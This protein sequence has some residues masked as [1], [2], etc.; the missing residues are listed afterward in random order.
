VAL[1]EAG[2]LCG[3]GAVALGAVTAALPGRMRAGLLLQAAG[4]AAA[5]AAALAVLCGAG[6]IG[7]AFT[8]TPEPRVGVD[9]LSAFFLVLLAVTAIPA[10]LAARDRLSGDRS[11]RAVAA[12]TGAFLLA[13]GGVL[14][15]RDVVTLLAAWELMSLAPAAA[16]LAARR[17]EPVRR[18][19]Y[20]YLA[21]THLGGTGV[22]VALLTLAHHGAVGDPAALAA[23]GA[24]VQ[25][26]VAVTA[27]VGFGTKAGLVPLHTWLPR[28]H[29]VAP[30]HLSALM[31][32]VMVKVA[33]YGLIRVTLEWLGATPRW[34][35]LAL[36]ASG[37]VSALGGALWALTRRD[38]KRLLAYS[39][40]ENVGIVALALGAAVLLA[41]AGRPG[42]AALAFAAALLH[43]AN[44]AIFKVLLFLAAGAIERAAG[45]L[46]LDRLGGLLR[47]M[48][49]TGGA[50]LVGAVAIAGL[51]PLN[52]FASEW[53]ALQ[54][55]AHLALSAGPATGVPGAVALAGLAAAAALAL[56]AFVVAAG[57]VLLGAPRR[58]ACAQAA[59]P[60]RA[61]RGALCALAALCVALGLVP[62]LLLPTL[63][64]L[65][66][67]SAAGAALPDAGA[68][69]ALPGTG[70]L[71]TV[72][73]AV[74][75]VGLAALL[76]RVRRGGRPAAAPAP[77]WACGQ[78]AVPALGWTAAGFTKPLRLGLERVLR[79]RREIEVVR[80]GGLVRRVRYAGEI[81]S[82]VDTV[83]Y[84]P[85]IRVALRA[86]TVARRLQSGSVRTYAV[87][88]LALVVGLLALVR[89]GALR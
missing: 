31:S 83:V 16:I 64:S 57:L 33:L 9:G 65:A 25:T 35:G 48:P 3:T 72:A 62:G 22:W 47:A 70:G 60:P 38:V 26:L 71:P 24:G 18:A 1:A 73:L 68:G 77:T 88:L 79:P 56:V 44:H 53:L 55:L 52:G 4:T 15:A 42:W 34:L 78:A 51:P 11:G 66:P 54:A 50:F 7:A 37:L 8:S 17:E 29:P 59:E 32:G 81:P 46:E 58:A 67:G 39:T 6:P 85:A 12:L 2:A 27:L 41:D 13:L 19:V 20:A 21:I 40:I 63:A 87:Y 14:V 5:G 61:T 36:L 74:A 84:E 49:W 75:L 10:L 43:A 30:A 28:A 82:L 69:I 76:Y 80:A 23:K 86:A 89:A 45:S